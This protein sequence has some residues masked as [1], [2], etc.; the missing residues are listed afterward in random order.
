MTSQDN[1]QNSFIT[2]DT[3]LISLVTIAKFHG[4]PADINQLRRAYVVDGN[5]MNTLT[6]LRASKDIGL[7]SR[8][9]SIDTERL[10]SMPFPA[11]LQLVNGNYIVVLRVEGERLLIVYPTQKRKF[12]KMKKLSCF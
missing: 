3:A 11:I 4:I 10:T 1:T 7:K 9:I 2:I 12:F 8:E 6:M 5:L